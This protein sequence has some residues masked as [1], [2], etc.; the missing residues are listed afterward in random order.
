MASRA[1]E[2]HRILGLLDPH[3]RCRHDGCAR[4]AARIVRHG[5]PDAQQ[6]RAGAAAGE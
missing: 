6:G 5:N 4:Q 1:G 2:A 3:R